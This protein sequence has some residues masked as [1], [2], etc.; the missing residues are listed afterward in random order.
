MA[1]GNVSLM[2]V[3]SVLSRK[4]LRIK[5]VE[6]DVMTVGCVQKGCISENYVAYLNR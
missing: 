5:L 4:E 3:M 6:I 1:I 2:S